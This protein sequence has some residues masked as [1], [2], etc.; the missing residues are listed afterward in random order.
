MVVTPLVR[1]ISAPIAA[2]PYAV[3]PTPAVSPTSPH[4]LTHPPLRQLVPP[5]RA[6][7]G[8]VSQR[9]S[10]GGRFQGAVVLAP[11]FGFVRVAA[12][13]L[14]RPA[15]L[16]G[17]S[18]RYS[19]RTRGHYRFCRRFEPD[20]P[21]ESAEIGC[22]GTGEGPE[23]G[24]GGAREGCWIKPEIRGGSKRVEGAIGTE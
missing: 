22:R 6:R 3:A 15:P 11:R 13:P 18:V 24:W 1:L 2:I 23:K 10:G 17:Y 5:D 19:S 8:S 16:C 4:Q 12:E 7:R 9:P 20:G 14:S 21:W